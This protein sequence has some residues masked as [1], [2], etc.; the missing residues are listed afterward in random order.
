[1]LL[2]IFKQ[3]VFIQRPHPCQNPDVSSAIPT[4]ANVIEM[5]HVW[6]IISLWL[7]CR[8]EKNK[9]L[10]AGDK[11]AIESKGIINCKCAGM[12]SSHAKLSN[13]HT[14]KLPVRSCIKHF[15]KTHFHLHNTINLG[16]FFLILICMH[17]FIVK[18]MVHYSLTFYYHL[19]TVQ[20]CS[21][22]LTFLCK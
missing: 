14:Q 17:F 1:M 18:A 13:T 21:L 2:C 8:C 22:W 4:P 15:H 6:D 9:I 16:F 19:L 3:V 5:L 20:T 11:L 12:R 10:L 7:P